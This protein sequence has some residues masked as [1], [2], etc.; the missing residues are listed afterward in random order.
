M[1]SVAHKNASAHVK[2]AT[3]HVLTRHVELI[4][5]GLSS[6]VLISPLSIVDRQWKRI[7]VVAHSI[8]ITQVN[9]VMSSP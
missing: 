3:K 9:G 7:A 8:A 6:S 2:V 4:V 1:Q 5:F